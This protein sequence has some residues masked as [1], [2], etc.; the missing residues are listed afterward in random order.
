MPLS[1]KEGGQSWYARN[2]LGVNQLVVHAWGCGVAEAKQGWPCYMDVEPM[3]GDGAVDVVGID[4]DSDGDDLPGL[5]DDG[6]GEDDVQ[7]AV[8]RAASC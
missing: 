2:R 1:R 6:E 8:Q 3:M 5:G 4:C 7:S